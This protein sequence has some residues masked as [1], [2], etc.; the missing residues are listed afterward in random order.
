MSGYAGM[1]LSSTIANSP[2]EICGAFVLTVWILSGRFLPDTR[3]WLKSAPALP[4]IG[5]ILLPWI[6]LL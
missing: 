4:I 1:F 2:V 3:L 5:M 6:G